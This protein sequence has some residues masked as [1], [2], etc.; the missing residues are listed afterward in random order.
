MGLGLC[1]FNEPPSASDTAVHRPHSSLGEAGS[2]CPLRVGCLLVLRCFLK[3]EAWE[4]EEEQSL[5]LLEAEP[6]AGVHEKWMELGVGVF[7]LL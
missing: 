6:G 2:E 5:V 7:F 1:I 4:K 3:R